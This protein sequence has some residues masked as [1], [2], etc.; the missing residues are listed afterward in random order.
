MKRSISIA[1]LEVFTVVKIQIVVVVALWL[2]VI[3]WQDY[4]RFRG[5]RCFQQ[6][7]PH[8]NPEDHYLTL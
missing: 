4:Q 6:L 2:W 5:P 7:V 1:R 8:H 3:L